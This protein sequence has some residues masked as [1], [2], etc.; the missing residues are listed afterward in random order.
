ME[1]IL[2]NWKKNAEDQYSKNLD[3]LTSINGDYLY[4]EKAATIHKEVFDK[5][6]CLQCANCCKTTPALLL[7]SDVK[8]IAKH[9]GVP[10]KTFIRK[11]TIE[12]INGDLLFNG[13]PCIF[14]H[15]DNTCKIYAVR[16]KACRQ[17][18]H[19]DQEGFYRRSKMNAKNTIVCPATYEIIQQLKKIEPT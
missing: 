13:V 11:Y 12:D 7:K 4:D 17:F 16:P 10:P 19:T 6:D 15:E 1:E 5:V 3:F 8:K 9:L 2:K 18:P 14:L